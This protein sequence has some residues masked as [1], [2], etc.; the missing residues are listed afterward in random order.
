MFSFVITIF[1]FLRSLVHGMRDAEFR[2]LLYFV[3]IILLSGT[4]F[5]HGVE[6]WSWLDSLFFSVTSLT[7]VGYGNLVPITTIGKIFTIIYIFLGLGTI[8]GFVNAVAHH[9][10]EDAR[11]RMRE[12]Q[13]SVTSTLTE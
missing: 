6:H 10:S 4:A 2:G 1:R 8:L 7:T 11:E 5:Y 3:A 12:R 13:R 9:A